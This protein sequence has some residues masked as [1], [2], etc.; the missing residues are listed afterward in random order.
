MAKRDNAPKKR[1]TNKQLRSNEQEWKYQLKLL[2][3]RIRKFEKRYGLKVDIQALLEDYGLTEFDDEDIQRLKEIRKW[4]YNKYAYDPNVPS[5]D[6]IEYYGET[7]YDPVH[8]SDVEL[9]NIYAMLDD[10]AG[11]PMA[12][13]LKGYLDAQINKD[14][15]DEVAI[16]IAVRYEDCKEVVKTSMKYRPTSD[17]ASYWLMQFKEII[18]GNG[19]S[20]DENIEASDYNFMSEGEEYLD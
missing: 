19:L 13:R 14:G 10:Y 20:M 3:D 16:R 18:T 2:H 1:K 6:E 15:R 8:I 5:E 12:I 7:S 11:N 4:Q 17:R 9:N